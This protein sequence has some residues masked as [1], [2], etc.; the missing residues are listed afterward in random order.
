MDTPTP[1]YAA[2]LP[3]RFAE[4]PFDELPKGLQARV[5]DA[6]TPEETP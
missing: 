6:I 1:P 4:T 2:S 5:L 3:A